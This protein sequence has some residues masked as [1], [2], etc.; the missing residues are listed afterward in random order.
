MKPRPVQ[1]RLTDKN[2]HTFLVNHFKTQYHY[3]PAM[4]EAILRDIV[5]ARTLLDPLN[6]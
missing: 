1:E 6:P 4:T 3:S 2:V 5:F